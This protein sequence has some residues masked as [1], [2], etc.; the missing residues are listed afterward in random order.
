MSE[1]SANEWLRPST[2]PRLGRCGHYRPEP[3]S[4]PAAARGRQLDLVFRA[5]I[6]GENVNVADLPADDREAVR[7]AVD[8]A[9]ALSGGYA[10]EAREEYLRATALGLSGT[11]DLLCAGAGWSADLKT[12]QRHSYLEQQA[13]YALGFMDDCF[14]DE[15]TVYL[16]YCD[17]R[18]VETFRF[19]RLEAERIIRAAL[20]TA[21]GEDS[22]Q[23]NEYCGWCARRFD[24][25]VRTE[26]MGI[27]P[28]EGAQ[29]HSLDT[30]DSTLLREFILRAETVEDFAERARDIL[31]ARCLAGE[32]IPGVSLVSKRGARRIEAKE[33]T[34]LIDKLGVEQVLSALGSLSES[35]AQ[36]LWIG[37]SIEIPFP[38]K[39]VEE[40][41]GSSFVR[42]GRPRS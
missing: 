5:L 30:A 41:P 42:I 25:A 22:P 15:W 16:F 20:A 39:A 3:D 18:E 37:S 11:A 4:G 1:M 21:R 31:K 12:G 26:S 14:L 29:S 24:C 40:M 13:A 32:R 7:W 27:F 8:T 28:L 34:P 10:L 35:R 19:K 38:A 6:G 17:L 9:R 23:V 2:L 36:E 33:L